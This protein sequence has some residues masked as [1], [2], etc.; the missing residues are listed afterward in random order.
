M[1]R[2][3]E[4]F[5]YSVAH[6]LRS[7]LRSIDGFSQTLLDDHAAQLDGEA[8][9]CLVRVQESARY[10]A[11]LIDN[12]L[13]LARITQGEIQRAPVDL[14]AVGRDVV[15][16][17]QREMPE[18]RVDVCIADGLQCEGDGRLIRIAFAN[19]LGNAWKFTRQRIDPRIEIGVTREAGRT[20]FL[21]RDNG[22]GF[23]M[24]FSDKLFGVF[25]RLHAQREFE[26]TGIGL[27]TVQRIVRRHGGQIWADAAVGRGATFYFTLDEGSVP[28]MTPR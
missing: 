25:Q 11:H 8:R 1:S 23:D 18:H 12:L 28:S 13:L 20:V 24:A 3:Y 7:P 2:E 26:G 10:M 27:A 6:D 14:S 16:E 5:S 9:R 17:L 22:A 15:D 19:L 4:A 21:I